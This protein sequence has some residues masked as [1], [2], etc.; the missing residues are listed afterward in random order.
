M[1]TSGLSFLGFGLC[2]S[3][4]SACGVAA[5]RGELAGGISSGS[6]VGAETI[7]PG[8]LTAG[9]WDDNLNFD[10]FL[11]YRGEHEGVLSLDEAAHRAAHDAFATRGP[12]RTLDVTLVIDTTG[13][14]SDEIEY[15]KTELVALHD[16]IGAH[17]ADAEQRWAIV[18]Y[19]DEGD[20]YVTRSFD[21]RDDAAAVSR[22]LGEQRA[23][24]GGDFPEAP[25]RALA[26]ANQLHWRAD[27]DN[28]RVVFWVADAPPHEDKKQAF[29]AAITAASNQ[30]VHIYPVASSGIDEP[31]ELI[32]RSAAQLTG[33]RYLFL[34]DDSGVGGEHK[35]PTLPCYYVTKLDAA[36]LRM[37]HIEMTGVYKEPS[38]AEIIR[39]GG[40]PSARECTLQD[41]QQVRAF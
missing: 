28:A 17:Y 29:V 24:G 37:I 32:M 20:A 31:T 2:L 41:G 40:N 7:A 35:V 6:S 8:T 3:W 39:T 26:E 27:S 18:V 1:R 25:D 19:R 9:A 12:K 5:P 13:S 30:D 34:T 10:Y 21:F 15:L 16:T 4:L 22:D 14:M 33:G 11:Q 38:S 23:D 36:I